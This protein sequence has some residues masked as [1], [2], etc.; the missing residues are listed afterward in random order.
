MMPRQGTQQRLV[1]YVIMPGGDQ[2]TLR[3]ACTSRLPAYMVPAQAQ[4]SR[5]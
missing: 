2:A 4:L 5:I 1:A 3:A